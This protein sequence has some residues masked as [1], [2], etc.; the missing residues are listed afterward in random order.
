MSYT[1]YLTNV[2][3]KWIFI[4]GVG[5]TIGAMTM[6]LLGTQLVFGDNPISFMILL[7][8]LSVCTIV[9]FLGMFLLG[10]K[11][12]PLSIGKTEHI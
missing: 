9:G 10:H 11:F 1:H 4:F 7:I 5:N 3:K 8:G 6:P 12:G 2:S